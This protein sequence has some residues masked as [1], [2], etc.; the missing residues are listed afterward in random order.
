MFSLRIFDTIE[1]KPATYKERL[2]RV[3]FKDG[4]SD[5]LPHAHT[6]SK[7]PTFGKRTPDAAQ[8]R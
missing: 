6:S 7:K 8:R 1:V 5:E 2:R 3:T 4:S